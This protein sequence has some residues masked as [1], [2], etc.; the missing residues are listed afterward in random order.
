[1]ENTNEETV[2]HLRGFASMKRRGEGA[3]K[4][5]AQGVNKAQWRVERIRGRSNSIVK[6]QRN[7]PRSIR[8]WAMMALH[9]IFG[10]VFASACFSCESKHERSHSVRAFK[11]G[12]KSELI[13]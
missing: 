11:E 6:L 10:S 2:T 12:A 9:G 3:A 7:K 4:R 1:M 5:N 13:S 8:G